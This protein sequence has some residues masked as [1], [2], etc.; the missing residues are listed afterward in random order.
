MQRWDQSICIWDQSIPTDPP[1][2]CS[3]TF[4]QEPT[5]ELSTQQSSHLP[6][7]ILMYLYSAYKK[8]LASPTH[9]LPLPQQ[10]R[11][12]HE[13]KKNNSHLE[14]ESNWSTPALPTHS[15]A[16]CSPYEK[17]SKLPAWPCFK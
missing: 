17:K 5:E 4:T 16:A 14:E 8:A 10:M 15:K 13:I 2:S 12:F 7:H 9:L 6:D 11:H 1:Q 3:V